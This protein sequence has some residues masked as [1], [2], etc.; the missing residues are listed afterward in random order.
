MHRAPGQCLWLRHPW[1]LQAADPWAAMGVK[2]FWEL[3]FWLVPT[4]H[5]GQEENR[6]CKSRNCQPVTVE[7]HPQL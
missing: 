3:F 1:V 6:A 2:L 4:L 7:R 5:A